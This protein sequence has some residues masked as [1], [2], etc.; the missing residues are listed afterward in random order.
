MAAPG[1][2]KPRRTMMLVIS[3]SMKSRRK[4]YQIVLLTIRHSKTGIFRQALVETSRRICTSWFPG[5]LNGWLQT[6]WYSFEGP[7]ARISWA[8]ILA[9]PAKQIH[10]KVFSLA[11]NGQIPMLSSV[12]EKSITDV[13]KK[14]TVAHTHGLQM[15]LTLFY[16]IAG[17]LGRARTHEL[18]H[19]VMGL[20]NKPSP[21]V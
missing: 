4:H 11:L 14:I 16:S 3:H 12:L 7:D 2:P 17:L 9:H 8:D 18:R 21:F 6:L 10:F 13:M 15:H 20:H 1:H 19:V 5:A